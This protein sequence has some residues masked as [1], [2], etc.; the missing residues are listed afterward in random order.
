MHSWVW[1]GQVKPGW[2][3][4]GWVGPLVIWGA[5]LVRLGLVWML[6][7]SKTRVR[8]LLM[9]EGKI[10]ASHHIVWVDIYSLY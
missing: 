5:C 3:W 9:I 2:G 7:T 10:A 4:L 1:L 6:I 8:H